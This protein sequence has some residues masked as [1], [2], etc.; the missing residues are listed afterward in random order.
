MRQQIVICVI[1][2]LLGVGVGVGGGVLI[3]KSK[4]DKS[5]AIIADL[6][7]RMQKSEMISQERIQNADAEM[8]RLNSEL[9]R[10]KTELDRV[11]SGG[12][13]VAKTSPAENAGV[14]ITSATAMDNTQKTAMTVYI[15]KEGDS[16][17]KIA[18]SQLGDGN[19]YK[20]IMKLNPNVSTNKN[21]VVGTKL[22]IP[23]R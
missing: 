9:M 22:K 2:A 16:L 15:V 17:W 18:A 13:E 7:S 20:E 21:L 12:G 10:V 4:V 3:T 14:K 1:I 6:Q 23:T 5:K 8:M 11:K 19:R